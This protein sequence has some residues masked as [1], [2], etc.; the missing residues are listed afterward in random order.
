MEDLNKHFKL[1]WTLLLSKDSSLTSYQWP[2]D[3]FSLYY[4]HPNYGPINPLQYAIKVNNL[5]LCNYL[6]KNDA[7][8]DSLPS[9]DVVQEFF[10]SPAI[11]NTVPK[12]QDGYTLLTLA[13]AEGHYGIFK[14]LI[15]SFP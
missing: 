10:A 3:V 14:S 5:N 15:R 6:L 2:R 11:Y 4:K 13:A 8:E 12:E 7:Y 9:S 1:F